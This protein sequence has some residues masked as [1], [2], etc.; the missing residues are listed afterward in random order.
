MLALRPAQPNQRPGRFR[1]GVAA[2]EALL[3]IP[4]FLVVVL[5]AV[6]VGDLIISEQLLAEASA[7]AARTAALGGTE[8]QVRQCVQIVL[9]ED[10]AQHA[11]ISIGPADGG[12][13]PIGPGRLIE[14]RI[15]L[16]CRYATTTGL[17]PVPDDEP[18]VGRCVMQRE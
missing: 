1:R 8:D 2:V 16:D 14:V 6:G 13:G 9:G 15:E 12:D 5:G 3:A 4:L 17:A 10:R 7:R 11:T 18:L